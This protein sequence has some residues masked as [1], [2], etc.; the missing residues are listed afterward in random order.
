MCFGNGEA[1]M[2]INRTKT[3]NKDQTLTQ[4]YPNLWDIDPELKPHEVD[5]DDERLT[6]A[7]KTA[8]QRAAMG[9]GRA[10]T[11]LTGPEGDSSM[12]S[13]IT[14]SLLGG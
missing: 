2:T 1:T 11:F 5:L 13:T 9:Y 10:Q 12:A 3:I 4:A 7:R 6:T 8:R 14:P